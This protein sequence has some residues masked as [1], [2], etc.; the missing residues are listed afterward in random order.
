VAVL[1]PADV[2]A[3]GIGE[4]PRIPVGR[5]DGGDHEGARR[6]GLA[7]YIHLRVRDAGRP[8][9]GAVEAQQLSSSTADPISP[10]S[11][12]RRSSSAGWRSRAS[13][14]LP[15]RFTVVSWP[16]MKSST[17]GR[18]QLAFGEPVA[19]LLDRDQRAEEIGAGVPAPLGQERAEV[20]GDPAPPDA[21]ALDDGV[22]GG[23]ADGVEA[24]DDVGGGRRGRR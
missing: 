21:P 3:V 19:L 5:A 14:P 16:A 1:G 6:Q 13:R 2:K 17:P 23:D 24:A 10:G 4:V 12:R 22:V 11:E 9:H 20:L 8:L 15:I 18:E 7:A